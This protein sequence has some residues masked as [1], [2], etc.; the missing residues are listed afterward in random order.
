MNITEFSEKMDADGAYRTE[1]LSAIAAELKKTGLEGVITTTPKTDG[2]LKEFVY[3]ADGTDVATQ[4]AASHA[5]IQALKKS[6]VSDVSELSKFDPDIDPLAWNVV[7][8]DGGWVVNGMVDDG[9]DG[10]GL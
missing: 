9:L 1:V 5:A 2:T 3:D 6:G 10:G 8:K 7:Y 4:L